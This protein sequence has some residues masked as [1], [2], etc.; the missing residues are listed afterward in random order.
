[1]SNPL[2]FLV[3]AYFLS[4]IS[5]SLE[6]GLLCLTLFFGLIVGSRE[7]VQQVL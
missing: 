4:I 3:D 1:M 7:G 6:G 5:I 2:S